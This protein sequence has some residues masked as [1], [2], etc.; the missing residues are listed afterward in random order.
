MISRMKAMIRLTLCV[1]FAFALAACAQV[2]GGL[3]QPSVFSPL[4]NKNTVPSVAA[5]TMESENRC[6]AQAQVDYALAV[7]YCTNQI[8]SLPV[9]FTTNYGTALNNLT[10]QIYGYTSAENQLLPGVPLTI[11][12]GGCQTPPVAVPVAAPTATAPA[13]S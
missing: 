11:S 7:K 1:L 4:G 12:L 3:K 8:P 13:A 9:E 5:L 2:G 6:N 10:C